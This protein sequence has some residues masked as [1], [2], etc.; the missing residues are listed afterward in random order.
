[1]SK[2]MSE[3]LL[4]KFMRGAKST[5][6]KPKPKPKPRSGSRTGPSPLPVV[7]MPVKDKGV[8]WKSTIPE[9]VSHKWEAVRVR[10]GLNKAEFLRLLALGKWSEMILKVMSTD[11]SL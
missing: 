6:P 2:K 7:E 5:T 4:E 3:Q 10:M 11:G 8:K 1:M 9:G